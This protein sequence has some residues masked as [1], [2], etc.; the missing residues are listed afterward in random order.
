MTYPEAI[1]WLEARGFRPHNGEYARTGIRIGQC[2][3]RRDW[4]AYA[5][6]GDWIEYADTPEAA[7]TA[8]LTTID[9]IAAPVRA[10]LRTT[11]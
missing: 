5:T 8:L 9:A 11:P 3:D 6:E 4:Y 2:A 10:A 7:L 1:A